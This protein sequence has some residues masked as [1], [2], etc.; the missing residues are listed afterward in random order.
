MLTHLHLH[1]QITGRRTSRASLTL[2]IEAD[3]ITVIDAGRHLHLQ[4][5][6]LFQPPLAVTFPARFVDHLAAAA[7]CRACL[8]DRE[9]AVLHAHAPMPATRGALAGLAVFRTGAITVLT[10]DLGGNP[11]L[12]GDAEYGFFQIHLHHVTQIGT[13]LRTSTATAMA[14]EDIAKNVTKH[15]ADVTETGAAATACTVLERGVTLLVIQ[16][17]LVF[18]TEDLV[19]LFGFL[20]LVLG[21]RIIRVAVGVKLHGEAAKRFLQL[22]RRRAAANPQHLVIITFAHRPTY[23]L[24]PTTRRAAGSRPRSSKQPVP[25]NPVTGCLFGIA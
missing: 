4:R 23:G 20:E 11:D 21:G 24:S 14:P 6:G 25:G 15:V 5:A 12:P 3:T 17:A 10:V 2:A 13:T 22:S 18:I 16:R 9:D 7:T 1:V 8:L 19:S